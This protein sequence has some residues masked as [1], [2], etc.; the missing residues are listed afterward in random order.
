MVAT[1]GPGFPINS[2][3][4]A[5][6]GGDGEPRPQSDI[7]EPSSKG[8]QIK[9]MT[10]RLGP[11]A[12]RSLYMT[13]SCERKMQRPLSL[14]SAILLCGNHSPMTVFSSSSIIVQGSGMSLYIGPVVTAKTMSEARASWT[15]SLTKGMRPPAA[16]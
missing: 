6:P 11:I 10:K 14:A 8:R 2:R 9:G 13:K 7:G 12:L 4:Y 1:S 3:T 15:P 5:S 16:P